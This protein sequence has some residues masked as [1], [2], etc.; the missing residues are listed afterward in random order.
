MDFDP[1]EVYD[2]L[3]ALFK[4]RI[5]I[6]DGAMGTMI[7]K[8]RLQEK[9]Y[10]GTRFVDHPKDL[11][12]NNDL[13]TLTQPSIIEDIHR[14]YLEAGADI[15]ET[16]TFNGTTIAQSDFASEEYAREINVESAR[17]A[18]RVADEITARDPSHRRFVAG[19]IGPTSKTA[20]VSRN[21]EDPSQRD[22][23]FDELADAYYEEIDAL[24]AGGAHIILIETIFD[25]LNAKAGLWAYQKYFLDKKP[26]PLMISGTLVDLSGRTLS[27]QTVE[28]FLIS[29]MHAK[30]LCIGLNCAL[31]ATNM[32]PF[33]QNLA[34]LAPFYVHAYPNAGL[35]NSMG[36]YDEDA[37]QFAHNAMTFVTNKLVNMIGGCCGTTPD[38]I[39]A[40]KKAIVDSKVFPREIPKPLG[41]LMLSGLREFIFT[42]NIPFI[43]IGERCNISGSLRFKKLLITDNNYEAALNVA[44]DQVTN[45]AQILD[46]NVDEGMIDSVAVM[47][48]FLKMLNSDPDIASVPLMIDSSNFKVIEAGLKVSQGKCIVNSISLKNGE[49][50]FLA[51]ARTIQKY[52]AAVVCMAFDETGQA[53]EVEHKVRICD[54][55]YDL[56]VLKLNFPPEDIIFDLNILTIAT[57]MEEHNPYARNFIEATRIIRQ[58]YP[59]SHISGGL[60]NLSF[61]FR[62]LAQFRESMHAV[63][64]YHAIKAGMD[65]GIINAGALPIYEDIDL[66]LRK[67]FE[68]IIFNESEDGKHVERV[69]E[70]AEKIK[71]QGGNK[72]TEKKEAEWR[73]LPCV[74]RLKHALVNGLSEFIEI[75]LQ[76]ALGCHPGPLQIIE[77]P[78]MDGM[79][80]VGDLF[81]SGRMFLPQVIKSARVMK[82]GIA[83]LEPLMLR[84][85]GSKKNGT[86]L[87]ATVKGDVHDIGKNIVGVVLRCNNYEVIDLGV[88][89]HWETIYKTIQTQHIDIVGLSGLITPSLEHMVNYAKNMEN[90]G[91][92]LPLI[93]GG[94]TT[95]KIH[96]AVKIAPMYS[97]PAVHVLDASRSVGVVAALIDPNLKR[98]FFAEIKEEYNDLRKDYYASQR[99]KKFKTLKEARANKF[100]INWAGYTPYKPRTEGVIVIEDQ[101]LAELIPYIDWNPF[102]S[103]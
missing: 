3:D 55:V 24:Y 28:A 41:H 44:R 2:Y 26:L 23:S 80:V 74:D 77:G 92:S 81:G 36:G 16:N 6:I 87:M 47:A 14:Q 91:L 102:F 33:L 83:F 27:G 4:T 17:L 19:A 58:K 37:D 100:E 32:F 40:L 10:R 30:P 88:Q 8:H 63:F 73:S 95:S 96:T 20:S 57:G 75:D 90:L 82:Q 15:I 86:I 94:A 1:S 72:A 60:S 49:E 51:E 103:V 7:Q 5:V 59:K 79:S 18:R 35:P 99:E 12:N 71:R 66:E 50:E 29:M 52:G 54:R 101:D 68:E 56:L 25:T 64:L 53:T 89:V 62:A 65:M 93:I 42:E 98:G 85:E 76:E 70:Y 43:N 9:D 45:G 38:H 21:V 69:I 48:K 78:L 67:I 84:G 11:M 31:G 39:R 97:N 61:S 22:I 13:L 46:V 34:N